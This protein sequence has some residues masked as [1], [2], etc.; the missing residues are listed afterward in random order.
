MTEW[1]SLN[2]HEKAKA[3]YDRYFREYVDARRAEV[4]A[5]IRAQQLHFDELLA[6]AFKKHEPVVRNIT[7]DDVA[8]I[9]LLAYADNGDVNLNINVQHPGMRV[10]LI[11]GDGIKRLLVFRPGI[12]DER[13]NGILDNYRAAPAEIREIEV[14]AK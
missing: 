4:D 9:D 12:E 7:V 6:N 5:N 11:E 10:F 8:E 2:D 3:D 14:P 1:D 13:R